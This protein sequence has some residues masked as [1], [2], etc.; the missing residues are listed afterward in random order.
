M[1]SAL[2]APEPLADLWRGADID[3]VQVLQ[4]RRSVGGYGAGAAELRF[5]PPVV[6]GAQG[7]VSPLQVI[8]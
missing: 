1:F 6:P 2:S 5:N 7:I 3:P 8:L 4:V